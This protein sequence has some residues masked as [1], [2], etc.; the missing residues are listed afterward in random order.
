MDI[1]TTFLHG[2]LHEDIYMQQPEGLVEK[3]KEHFIS[4]R[5][6]FMALN[7]NQGNGIIR[8]IHLC[9][10]KVIKEVTLI[11]VFILSELRM[12]AC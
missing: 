12:V 3:C 11:I 6:V 4:S 7:R 1:K 5:R 8:S 9:S 2:D 10:L